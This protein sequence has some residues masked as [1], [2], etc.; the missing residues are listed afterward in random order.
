[1]AEDTSL[2]NEALKLGLTVEPTLAVSVTDKR[3]GFAWDC[4]GAPFALH[5]WDAAQYTVRRCPVDRAHGW[6][7]RAIPGDG[8]VE[9]QCT[10]PRVACSFRVGFRLE[11]ATLDVSLP[12]RRLVENEPFDARL[13]AIDILLGLGGAKTG[14]DGFLFVPQGNGVLCRLDKT[15]EHETPLLFYADGDHALTAPAF[16]MARGAAGF[17]GV[18]C[19]NE[20]NA[21]LVVAANRGPHHDRSYVSP[22][23][24]VRFQSADAMDDADS[25]VRYTF[26]AGDD[27]SYAGMARAYRTYLLGTLRQPPLAKRIALRPMLDY[28][29]SAPTVHVRLAEKR[30]V[31]RMTGGGEL[32]VETRFAEVADIARAI[33]EAGIEKATVVLDGWN[34]DGRDGLYP[35]RFPVESAL[36]G[37][38]AMAD[39]LRALVSLGFQMGALDNYTDMYRCSPGFN[40]G[41]SA[42]QLGG[43]HWRG[44]IAAGG[45]SYIVCPR[46]ARERHA[47]RDMRRLRDL[48]MEGLL[49]LDYFPGPGVLRCY[50]PRHP[51]P[52]ARYAE[53]MLDIIRMAQTTFGICR[54][55]G[56]SV[57]AALE[58]DS[59]MVPVRQPADGADSPD[60]WFADESVPFLPMA[61]HGVVLLAAEADVD[62]L[63]VVEYGAAPVYRTAKPESAQLLAKMTDFCKR[64]A[65]EIVPLAEDFIQTHDTPGDGLVKVGY[66]GGAQILINRTD[67]PA[68]IDGVPVPPQDFH[69]RS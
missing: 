50:D 65:A 47:Q 49:F 62:P 58:A 28:A 68:E 39:A 17:L 44:R 45:R 53:H 25:L 42:K 55:S 66:A 35:A 36:G 4:A 63:R 15:E 16:G 9:V 21:E 43:G 7:F 1:M 48:G 67:G 5:Y 64:H 54:V 61:L 20:F 19:Y 59:C 57:F 30:R 12:G 34:C 38:D 27:A 10:W 14:E 6:E 22:R 24:R 41:F 18:V 51:L 56:P 11:G 46:E 3:R 60:G 52:R 13:I 2:E 8:E 29:R 40:D 23:M 26:L 33:H 32:K 31:S 69:V 37:A